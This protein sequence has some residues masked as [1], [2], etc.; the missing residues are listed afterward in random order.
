[1]MEKK[2]KKF[3]DCLGQK[4]VDLENLRKIAWTGIPSVSPSYRS[5]IWK[6]LLDYLPTDSEI[7]RETINR[8]REE[9]SDMVLHYFGQVQFASVSDL[10]SVADQS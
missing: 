5:Q 10:K 4:Q 2:I 8:K 6:L 1:M 3:D 9:Y 7:Q